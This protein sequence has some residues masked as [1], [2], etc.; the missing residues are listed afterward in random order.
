VDITGPAKIDV[1]GLGP[2][3]RLILKKSKAAN[4]SEVAFL[5][6]FAF[7]KDSGIEGKFF[8]IL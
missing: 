3:N 8:L 2:A 7:E 1:P 4:T 5:Y 6:G